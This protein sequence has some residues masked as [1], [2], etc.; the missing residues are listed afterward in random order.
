[1]ET[2]KC[3]CRERHEMT[4]SANLLF[5]ETRAFF[6]EQTEKGIYEDIPVTMPYHIGYDRLL[7]WERNWYASKLYQRKGCGCL[8]ELDYPSYPAKAF[9]R[10]FEDGKY[11]MTE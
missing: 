2:D 9:I 8:W 1:M 10:K 6:E 7:N 11:E 4:I 5:E 3:G